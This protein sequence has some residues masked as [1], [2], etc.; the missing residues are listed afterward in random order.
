MNFKAP[1]DKNWFNSYQLIYY[2]FENDPYNKNQNNNVQNF[3]KQI[4]PDNKENESNYNWPP[5]EETFKRKDEGPDV[6]GGS[7]SKQQL[8]PASAVLH[9][10]ISGNPEI[11]K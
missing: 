7:P 8:Q 2:P 11:G 10:T 3:K 9:P 6:V 1:S 5:F 4:E